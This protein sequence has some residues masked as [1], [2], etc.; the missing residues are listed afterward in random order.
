[1]IKDKLRMLREHLKEEKGKDE[2][3]LVQRGES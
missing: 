1:M 3:T 2:Q